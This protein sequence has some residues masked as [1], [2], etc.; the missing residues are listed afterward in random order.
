MSEQIVT[1]GASQ[2]EFDDI[3]AGRKVHLAI[4]L[5]KIRVTNGL[6]YIDLDVQTA[7]V[8]DNGTHEHR[9]VQLITKPLP[10]PTG[11]A[12]GPGSTDA[13]ASDAGQRP[14]SD[15]AVQGS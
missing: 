7:V 5:S 9:T 2:A 1:I 11:E 6:D 15:A 3:K 12:N 13:G 8:A 10:V 14:G 4:P